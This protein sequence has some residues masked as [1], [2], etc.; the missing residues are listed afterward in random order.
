MLVWPII[1]SM[2][3]VSL[4]AFAHEGDSAVASLV[5][6]PFGRVLAG[7]LEECLEFGGV[8]GPE[9]WAAVPVAEEMSRCGLG[10]SLVAFRYGTGA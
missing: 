1:S 8:G 10:R 2:A 6:G 9:P 5:P 7:L 3:L 4:P